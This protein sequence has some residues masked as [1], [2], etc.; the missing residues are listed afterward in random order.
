MQAQMNIAKNRSTY[1]DST[2]SSTFAHSTSLRLKKPLSA[3]R[4]SVRLACLPF[5]TPL[6]CA[7]SSS[8][9]FAGRSLAPKPLSLR[10][11]KLSL[12]LC[13]S[14]DASASSS[15]SEPVLPSSSDSLLPSSP[16]SPSSLPSSPPSSPPSSTP[17]ST[18][19]PTP[20]YSREF[21]LRRLVVF[22]SI[23][24]GYSSYYLTRN[25]L[26][27]TA[28][29]MVADTSLSM[30]ITQIGAMTSVFPIAYGMS[31]FI[32]G[33]LGAK[34][35]PTVLL[36][37]G[38][39]ATAATNFTFACGGSLPWFVFFWAL[40]GTLQGVGGPCC[41]RILTSWFN[42][43]E[44]GTY[45]GMWNVAHNVG[46]FVAPLVAGGCSKQFGWKWGMWAP[47]AIASVV[48]LAVA[49]MCKDRPE[50]VGFPPVEPVDVALSSQAR[51]AKGSK[52]E[53]AN[54]KSGNAESD[55]LG[56]LVKNVLKNPFIW[57]LAL[58]YFFIYIVRQGV[59]SWFV[60]YLM[61]QKGASDAGQ[62]AMRVSG[63]ELGGLVGSLAAGRLSDFLIKK[64]DGKGGNVGKR[65]V[66]VMLY[67][68]GVAAALLAFRALPASAVS[69][70]WLTVFLIG[71]FLYGPQ[72]LI[73][74]CGAEL[75]GPSSV[76]ASE[77]FL[78]WVAYLGAANAGIPLSVVVKE[79]GWD[80]YFGT[81]IFACG[82]AL[83]L[84]SPMTKLR[85]YVQREERRL[86]REA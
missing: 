45:W 74:L 2:L 19:T 69:L 66:V 50:D 21:I 27:Y 51:S 72:M 28:P 26:T 32:S 48:G 55:I 23:V 59:T 24:L 17:L 62:A 63:L 44:R 34:F 49:V 68:V 83:L 76:G 5:S 43:A 78:G 80:A 81:L 30:D 53:K 79:H 61:K 12:S 86:R 46:G 25:S 9:A 15:S 64:A 1:K 67:T 13:R 52:A 73:G 36:S 11:T 3:A 10:P 85:S 65:I 35:S 58:T 84:L 60:F 82:M 39:L 6:V 40:N 42:G 33:V 16:S 4:P 47:A 31:K 41:A 56:Q 54:T 29:V 7:S 71:F 37:G 8:A 18:P 20:G 70:Q 77:G 38:L 14:I 22:L 75:V 57:G